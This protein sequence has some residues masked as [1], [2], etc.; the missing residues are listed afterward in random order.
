MNA[1]LGLGLLLTQT[2]H[3]IAY[4]VVVHGLDISESCT[5]IA[6]KKEEIANTIQTKV[7]G[8]AIGEE[9]DS[10]AQYFRNNANVDTR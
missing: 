3:T 2:P 7:N 8:L 1:D 5:D 10:E 9:A 6:F 4:V